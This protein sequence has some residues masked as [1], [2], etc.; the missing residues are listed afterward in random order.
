MLHEKHDQKIK[1]FESR[2]DKNDS[3]LEKS[4]KRANKNILL[5]IVFFIIVLFLMAEQ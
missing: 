1:K 4:N 2:I 3:I 5:F